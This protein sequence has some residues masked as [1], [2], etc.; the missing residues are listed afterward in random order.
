MTNSDGDAPDISPDELPLSTVTLLLQRAEAGEREAMDELMPL[1]Y[2]ELHRLAEG[3]F[4][5]RGHGHTLQPTALVNEVY[6]RIARQ[7]GA[8]WRG[9]E[10][11]LAVA[12]TAM[13]QV[14][15][16]HARR[17][18]ATKRG[19]AA[20]R[21][22]LDDVHAAASRDVD[23]VALD[24]A[25]GRLAELNPRHVRLVELRAFAG[26]SVDDT[27]AALG[28]SPRTVNNEWRFV[29]AWLRRELDV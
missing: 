24:E 15:V 26:L 23:L 18:S 13:R 12:A 6:L 25:L 11:F 1:V 4:R 7:Q 14:L 5:S 22:T 8:S 3:Q 27:A 28:V 19:G 9:R 10:H 17:R 29:Q 20:Q 16:D 21:V 2:G